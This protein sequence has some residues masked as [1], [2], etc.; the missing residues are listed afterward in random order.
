MKERARTESER[1]K[2]EKSTTEYNPSQG[3]N[4]QT[5]ERV[6]DITTNPNKTIPEKA[7]D[8]ATITAEVEAKAKAKIAELQ[9]ALDKLQ[10]DKIET[11]AAI[12]RA[13]EANDKRTEALAIKKMKE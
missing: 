13:Q 8:I 7:K 4:S 2:L 11:A 3:E 1:K 10:E 6:K 12:K 9:K 5:L